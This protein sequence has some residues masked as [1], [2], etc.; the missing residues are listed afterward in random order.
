M[1]DLWKEILYEVSGAKAIYSMHTYTE[2]GNNRLLIGKALYI[3]PQ[4]VN[5][6]NLE[7]FYCFDAL[8]SYIFELMG[9]K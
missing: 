6:G 8:K 2:A 7:I 4:M 9:L 1:D 3:Y 5:R